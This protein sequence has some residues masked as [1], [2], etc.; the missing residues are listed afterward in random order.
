MQR[1]FEAT[2][3]TNQPKSAPRQKALR[4]RRRA[5]GLK[6]LTRFVKVE[7]I[8]HIDA[9]IEKLKQENEK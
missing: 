2:T 8:P 7:W 1:K 4:D 6:T 9:L 3:I 5:E